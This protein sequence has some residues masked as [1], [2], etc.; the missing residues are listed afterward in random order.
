MKNIFELFKLDWKR[1]FKT[2]IALGLIMALVIIPSLYA[3]FNIWALW[4]PYS[5]TQDLKVG[6]YSADQSV[7]VMDKK[8][9]IG[10]ELV[11]ELKSNDQMGWQFAK[12]KADLDKKV[13]SGKYYAGIY[14]PKSF[15]KDLISFVDGKIDKPEIIYSSN[16]K[17]NA[18]APKITSKGAE[19]LQTTIS[20]EFTDVVAKTLM[21]T[22]NEVGF[23]LDKNLPMINRLTSLVLKT[24]AKI[25]EIDNYAQEVVALQAKLP[26]MKTKLDKANE[27]MGFLPEVNSM[28]NKLTQANQYLPEI[29]QAGNLAVKVQGKTGEIKNAGQQVK[30]LDEDFDGIANTLN[31]G[32]EEAK[33]GLTVLKDVQT[34]LPD[35]TEMSKEAQEL[36]KS[37]KN[38]LIPKVEEVLPVIQNS[39]DQSLVI[40][41]QLA[42]TIALQATQLNDLLESLKNDPNNAQI[43]AEI[44]AVLQKLSDRNQQL[45]DLNTRLADALEKLSPG[46][47]SEKIKEAIAKLRKAATFFN[48]AHQTIEDIITHFDEFSIDELQA[49]IQDVINLQNKILADIQTIIDANIGNL[50]QQELAKVK[51]L[52]EKGDLTLDQ[53]NNTIIPKLPGLLNNT[54]TTLTTAIDYLTKYQKEL[55]SLK[56]EIHDAN[57]L[58]NN[59]MGLII[60]GINTASSV[61]QNEYPLLKNKLQLATSFINNDLPGIEKDLTST[62]TMLNAKFPDIES[63]VNQA[64]DLIENDWPFLKESLQKGADAIRKGQKDVDLKELIKL[65]KRDANKES[66][67]LAKPVNIKEKHVYPIPNYGSAS[68]PFYTALCLWV[69]A[70]LLS[71]IVLTN[72]TLNESQKKKYTQKQQFLAR[73]LTYIVIGLAQALIVSLGNLFLLKTYVV[74]KTAFVFLS[75]FISII[76]MTIIYVM[77]AMFGNIGK[78]LAMVT[79]VLSIAGGG[80]NFPVVLSPKFF[81]IINPYLPFTYAVNLLREPTGGIYGPTLWFNFWILIAFGVVSFIIG[82]FLK[83]HI[84]PWFEKLHHLTEDSHI[85]H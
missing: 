68:A 38:D 24:D 84:N 64:V 19:A 54:E 8:V 80:G 65:L 10:E 62:M 27:F 76:F 74:D 20:D 63:A 18:I 34:V 29:E 4:D 43:K 49:K 25:P 45:A 16:D 5:K 67:F 75:L 69:G 56:Q 36:T 83:E 59:N 17:I 41:Q 48:Q 21:K 22:F 82:L 70:L 85:I 72:F 57:S 61:Y 58:L 33:G 52:L 3:W 44:K 12:S 73:W 79:L 46:E 47:Q 60:S 31:S 13:K 35:V 37:L 39:V 53:L 40:M 26:E 50:V 2:P 9:A 71:N 14:I 30:T 7:T 81:Q 32:I 6:V 78:G 1:I 55:P 11:D 15:S 42:T 51:A 28:A 77:A 66:D 23:D